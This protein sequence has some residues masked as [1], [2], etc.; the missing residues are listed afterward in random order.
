MRKTLLLLCILFSINTFCQDAWHFYSKG[1]DDLYAE[2][3]DDAIINYSKAIEKESDFLNLSIFY[4]CRGNA[5]LKLKNFSGAIAD[6]TKSKAIYRNQDLQAMLLKN[7]AQAKMQVNDYR[8]AIADYTEHIKSQNYAIDVTARMNFNPENDI[9]FQRTYSISYLSRGVAR[10]Q[11]KDFAG[12]IVDFNWAL[13]FEPTFSNAFYNRG[14]ANLALNKKQSACIDF[15]KAGELGYEG[16][17]SVIGKY[18]Q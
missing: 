17:Y 3:Y 6:Y 2:N 14:L 18:C 9:G 11:L 13:H 15:S 5:K 16:A 4:V 8:G 7:R 10:F 12:A 1:N